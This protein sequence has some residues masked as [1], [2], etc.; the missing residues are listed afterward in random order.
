MIS[1]YNVIAN[2][3]QATVFEDAARKKNG[4]D[5]QIILGLLPLSH[6]YGL[7]LISLLSEYRGDSVIIL[8]K[9]ELDSLLAAVH[10]FKINQLSVVPPILIQMLHNKEQ[11]DKYDLS[12]VRWVF[13][14]AA[15]LGSEVPE[16]LMRRYPQWGVGQG[17][18]EHQGIRLCCGAKS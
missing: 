2:V 3:I 11:C 9:F 15:P 13:S 8:P 7:T 6:I 16:A 4:V 10:N 1:H 14:G 12:S 5:T 17:Y 18:G